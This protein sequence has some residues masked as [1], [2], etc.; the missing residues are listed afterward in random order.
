MQKSCCGEAWSHLF[1][2]FQTLLVHKNHG[3]WLWKRGS[4]PL[5][6][7]GPE[8]PL[9][10]GCLS[11]HRTVAI[12]PPHTTITTKIK[13]T[14]NNRKLNLGQWLLIGSE[15]KGSNFREGW[16]QVIQPRADASGSIHYK[17]WGFSSF[18]F[19]CIFFIDLWKES[20]ANAISES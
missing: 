17:M 4:Q 7:H 9:L 1:V 10:M 8:W 2:N 16:H 6:H 3:Q 15:W 18:L 5:S 14:W 20:S 12:L 19:F 13:I 11:L